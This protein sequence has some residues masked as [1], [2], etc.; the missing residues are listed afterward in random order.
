MSASVKEI[1]YELQYLIG[2]NSNWQSYFEDLADYGLPRK[3][4]VITYRSKGEQLKFNY[5]YDSTAIRGLQKMA[6]GFHSNCTNSAMKWHGFEADNI[7]MMK[8]RQ[9][10][11]FFYKCELVQFRTYANSN[12]DNAFQEFY[13]DAGCFGSGDV[14]TSPDP[15]NV[16]RYTCVPIEQLHLVQDANGV[17]VKVF[18]VF[19][20]TAYQAFRMWGF[21]AGE[22]VRASIKDKKPNTKFEFVHY[23]GPRH[24]RDASKIDNINMKWQSSWIAKKDKFE[25]LQSGY[26]NNPHAVGRFWK[27]PNDAFGF[28]PMMNVLADVKL[29]NAQQRTVLRGAMKSVD[30]AYSLP[31]RGYMLP[32]NYNPGATNYRDVKLN[33]DNRLELM[34]TSPGGVTLGAEMVKANQQQI[35]DGLFLPLFQTLQNIGK[36][37]KVLEVQKIIA[38]NM[39]LLGPVLNNFTHDVITP[40]VLNT[41][42]C[43]LKA[44]KFPPIPPQ[45]RGQSF[46][47]VYYGQLARAQ[48]QSEITDID[49]LM[50]EMGNMVQFMPELADIPDPDYI[51]EKLRRFRNIDPKVFRDPAVIQARRQQKIQMA[52][53]QQK[54]DL[55]AKGAGAA[56]D[57]AKAGKSAAEAHAVNSGG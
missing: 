17:V 56:H 13:M 49:Q 26:D 36:E 57:V 28:S 53:A 10:Q 45:L 21:D 47:P 7:E 29:V 30:P 2:E 52:A 39:A 40:V 16:V 38:D 31:S 4:W 32:I 12:F 18:R 6:A 37:L 9:V 44:G 27:D 15:K 11:D 46:H 42:D 23:T 51:A 55:L 50:G 22:S 14:F 48:R 33:K 24:V 41:F 8:D 43:N 35:E 20:L 3:A 25:I 19:K 1:L 54:A 5:L 34:P